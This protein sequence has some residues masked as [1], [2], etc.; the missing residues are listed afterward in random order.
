LERLSLGEKI[1]TPET[2]DKQ[3]IA[4]FNGVLKFLQDRAPEAARQDE[5]MFVDTVVLLFTVSVGGCV[6]VHF[7]IGVPLLTRKTLKE[8]NQT[9]QLMVE[10]VESCETGGP[11]TLC[12]LFKMHDKDIDKFCTS[13][14]CKEKWPDLKDKIASWRKENG[15]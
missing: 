3:I 8:A 15:L 9:A 7:G 4:E 5:E 10:F 2:I 11:S 13:L 1:E 14:T 6:G 12:A